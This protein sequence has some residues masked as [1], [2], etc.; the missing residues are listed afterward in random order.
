MK[1]VLELD[2]PRVVEMPLGGLIADLVAAGWGN[3]D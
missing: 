2:A 3:G 1:R